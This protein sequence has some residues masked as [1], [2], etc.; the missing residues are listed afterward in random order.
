MPLPHSVTTFSIFTLTSFLLKTAI[1]NFVYRLR[2]YCGLSQEYRH[3]I[4]LDPADTSAWAN[5][6]A[7][8]YQNRD[9]VAARVAAQTSV[10]HQPNNDLA[11]EV[12]KGCAEC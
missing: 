3:V 5:L 12:L 9:F 8:L 7:I 2:L 4:R 11:N 6:A 10:M 1:S